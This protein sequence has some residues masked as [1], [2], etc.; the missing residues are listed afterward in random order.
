MSGKR[1]ISDGTEVPNKFFRE[2]LPV[3]TNKDIQR[4]WL[5]ISNELASDM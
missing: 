3:I 2:I 1:G 5:N 4:A